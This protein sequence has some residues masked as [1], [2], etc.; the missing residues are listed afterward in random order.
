M[1][2]AAK[3]C[4]FLNIKNASAKYYGSILFKGNTL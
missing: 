4:N 1:I 2:F 3:I